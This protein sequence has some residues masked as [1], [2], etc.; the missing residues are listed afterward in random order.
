M[1]AWFDLAMYAA[2]QR[3][4]TW[5]DYSLV[6]VPCARDQRDGLT[7]F[8]T[9]E[10]MYEACISNFIDDFGLR[11]FRRPVTEEEHLLLMNLGNNQPI[12]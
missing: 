12:L 6:S 11:A 3:F 7:N 1:S 10:E 4:E 9:D 8:A 2:Q 5:N